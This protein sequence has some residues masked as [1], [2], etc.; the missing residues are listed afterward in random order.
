MRRSTCRFPA[1][2]DTPS[3]A[4]TLEPIPKDDLLLVNK[5]PAWIARAKTGTGAGPAVSFSYFSRGLNLGYLDMEEWTDLTVRAWIETKNATEYQRVLSKDRIGEKG[6]FVLCFD[7]TAWE[8]RVFDEKT[9]D[10]R[11]AAWTSTTIN[12]GRPH[13]L[14]AVVDSREK[15]VSLYI[16][17]ELKAQ[18]DWTA[19]T[20]DDSD[21]TNLVVGADSRG[22]G[23][24][25]VFHGNIADVRIFHRALS[26][27][28]IRAL[29]EQKR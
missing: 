28:E 19:A 12:D 7:R 1:T 23:M 5:L 4:G 26:G 6:N 25:H 18:T 29:C 9:D 11:H 13:H 2:Y 21:K 8:F 17:G 10:W 3:D 14:G 27:E 24:G 15:K 22:A 16:D 20:L